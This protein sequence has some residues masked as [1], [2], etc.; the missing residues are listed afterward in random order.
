MERMQTGRVIQLDRSRREA[1][2]RPET[3]GCSD[4][5]QLLCRRMERW[6]RLQQFVYGL[7]DDYS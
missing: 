6:L 2:A 1:Q 7:P 3:Y 5:R 4:N